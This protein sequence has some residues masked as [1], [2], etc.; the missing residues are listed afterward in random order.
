ML[1]FIDAFQ[2][3]DIAPYI[4]VMRYHVHELVCHYGN[5]SRFNHQGL[6]KLNDNI[7][8]QYFRGTNHRLGGN[9]AMKQVLQKQNRI[10]LLEEH[11]RKPERILKCGICGNVGHTKVTHFKGELN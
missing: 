7:T 4:H 8:K 9:T 1:R 6:E 3:R 5:I 2:A 11:K 10:S